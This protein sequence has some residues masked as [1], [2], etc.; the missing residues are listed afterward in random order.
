[1]YFRGT[2]NTLEHFNYLS[3]TYDL[4]NLNKVVITGLSAG[5][6]ATYAWAQHL[7]DHTKTSKILA[8]AD[9]GL[10]ITDYY[11]PIAKEKIIRV[12][13]E[14]LL[15]LIG[16]DF[17]AFP[18]P[19]K[20]CYNDTQ[21]VVTC[22]DASNYAKYITAPLLMIESTYDAWVINNVLAINCL[23]NKSPPYSLSSCT[24]NE[25]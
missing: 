11:S 20:K 6:M 21:D 3:K 22:F 9:S 1:M 19:I 15:K 5:G 7:Q 4:F 24:D 23:K 2:N 10:F 25:R 8:I 16:Q 12:R 17:E 18:E 14:N 13:A